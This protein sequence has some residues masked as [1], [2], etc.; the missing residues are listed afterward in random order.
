MTLLSSR[1][2]AGVLLD[3][4]GTLWPDR[5]PPDSALAAS[6]LQA[7]L[8]GLAPRSAFNFLDQFAALAP[9]VESSTSQDTPALIARAAHLAGL[10]IPTDRIDPVRRAL[11]LPAAGRGE[12]F[13]GARELLA[14]I[15]ALGLRCAIVSN[16]AVRAG[17]DY[18][19]DFAGF[20]VGYLVDAFIS[21]V[22]TGV[23]KPDLRIFRAALDAI[24]CPPADVVVVGNSEPNDIEPAGR[25]GARSIRV[26]IE[27][28]PPSDTAADL[29]ATSLAE[30]VQALSAW[31]RP[32][33]TEPPPRF[34]SRAD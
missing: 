11:C 10:S 34:S 14:S 28:P 31:A 12:L 17:A 26:V 5:W 8:P 25:L 32:G 22:D 27:E 24:E 33:H 1:P 2:I 18:A 3:V 6:R 16:A 29:L 21:S 13:P 7:A 30:V 20:G 23:R 15:R 4:G 19:E 9:E